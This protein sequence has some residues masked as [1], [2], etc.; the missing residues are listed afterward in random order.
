MAALADGDVPGDELRRLG[1]VVIERIEIPGGHLD[2]LAARVQQ[3]CDENGVL[4][5]GG[6]WARALDALEPLVHV[7]DQIEAVAHA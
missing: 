7:D 5:V 1:A 4:P 6:A 2:R 3:I